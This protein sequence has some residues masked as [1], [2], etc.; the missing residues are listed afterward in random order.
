M[1]SHLLIDPVMGASGDM[2][3]A[4]LLDLGADPAAVERT[5]NA[6]GLDG[7]RIEFTHAETPHHIRY[8]RCR[9]LVGGRDADAPSATPPETPHHGHGHPHHD[10]PHDHGGHDH[11]HEPAA[12][13][14]HHDHR[15]LN[16]I[17]RMLAHPAMPPRARDRATRIFQRLGEAEAAVHG[18]PVEQVHFHEVGAVDSIAD[19]AGSCLALELLGVDHVWCAPL[20]AGTGTIRCAHG[21]LPNPAPATARLTEG[22]PVIR[23]PVDGELTTPTGAAILTTLGEGDWT[24]RAFRWLRTGTGQGSKRFGEAPNILR[25]ILAE[26]PGEGAAALPAGVWAEAVEVLETDIDDD[27]PELTAALPDLLRQAGAFDATLTPL[28]MKKGRPGV[29]VTALVPP[30]RVAEFAALVL[31][32]SGSIGVRHWP[33]QRFVLERGA[34]ELATPWGP[35]Q[36]KRIVRPGGAVE[37]T[38]EYES[39]REL[40]ARAGVPLRDV[41]LAAR[42]AP[43]PATG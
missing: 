29:R 42:R 33:A 1:S 2:I 28:L 40:A 18:I 4:A 16:D 3:L 43:A 25:A 10:Q 17:L 31:R 27:A 32:H 19:I 38:P 12:P 34:A 14:L 39:C 37:I 22:F 26:P 30:E 35:V 8:G 9:I 11:A 15:G 24:G 21:I 41:M 20:K 7:V 23:L 36:G 13:H 5:L 6:I